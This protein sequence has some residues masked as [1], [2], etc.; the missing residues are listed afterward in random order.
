VDDATG[1]TTA[2]A[3]GVAGAAGD[4]VV[5]RHLLFPEQQLAEDRLLRGDGV[6]GRNGLRRQRLGS[7]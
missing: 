2:D 5:A 6:L 3:E 1:V 7:Q 4:A